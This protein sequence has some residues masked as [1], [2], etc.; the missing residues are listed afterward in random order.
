[1]AALLKAK[2]KKAKA[3]GNSSLLPFSFLDVFR[4]SDT[5][6]KGVLAF[7]QANL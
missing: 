1:V 3:R 7:E 5:C 6:N 4:K 2:T